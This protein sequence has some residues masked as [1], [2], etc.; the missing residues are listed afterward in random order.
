MPQDFQ[1][2]RWLQIIKLDHLYRMVP[3]SRAKRQSQGAS[4]G[5]IGRSIV[6][7]ASFPQGR[8]I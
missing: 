4:P 2:E 3:Q 7:S 8:G 5:A 1:S 6:V